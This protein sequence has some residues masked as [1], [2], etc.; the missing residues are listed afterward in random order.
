MTTNVSM[1]YHITTR[2]R[3]SL[4]V[5]TKLKEAAPEGGGGGGGGDSVPKVYGSLSNSTYNVDR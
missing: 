5:G 3:N 4:C 1:L 2:R